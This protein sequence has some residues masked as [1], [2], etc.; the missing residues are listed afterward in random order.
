MDQRILDL[1][2]TVEELYQRKS[3]IFEEKLLGSADLFLEVPVATLPWVRLLVVEILVVKRRLTLRSLTAA[4]RWFLGQIERSFNEAASRSRSRNVSPAVSVGS[5]WVFSFEVHFVL[6]RSVRLSVTRLEPLFFEDFEANTM[7]LLAEIKFLC[8]A[9]CG[10][11]S[12]ITLGDRLTKVGHQLGDSLFVGLPSEREA[13]LVCSRAGV[14]WPI[15]IRL[16][17]DEMDGALA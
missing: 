17:M 3:A 9:G 15:Y 5:I 10:W 14:P 2:R 7:D 4:S 13:R 12:G 6:G 8:R 16:K 11:F 1:E